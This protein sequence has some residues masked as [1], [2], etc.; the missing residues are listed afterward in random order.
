M[1]FLQWNIRGHRANCRELDILLKQFKPS[2]VALQ[3]TL[4]TATKELRINNFN[5]IS[6]PASSDFARRGVSLYIRNSIF[7][8]N[9]PLSSDLE[10]AAARVS[11]NKTITIC[12]LYLS[13]STVISKIKL[14]SLIHQ[15][16]RP[17]LLL[18][19]F[20]GHSSFWGSADTNNQG[21]VIEDFIS[22]HSLCLLNTGSPTFCA[23]SGSLTHVDLS[24]CDPSLFLD[25]E[26]QVHSDLC[27]SDHFP[28]LTSFKK[29]TEESCREFWKFKAANWSLYEQLV[30]EELTLQVLEDS[31]DPILQFS[32]ILLQCAEK[33]I[34][35]YHAKPNLV[36]TPWFDEECKK[37]KNERKKAQRQFHKAPSDENKMKYQALRA[38]CRLTFKKKKKESWE[39]FCSSLSFKTNTQKVWKIIKK[40]NGK[41]SRESLKCLKVNDRV[42]SNKKEVADILANTFHQNSSSENY[43]E[44]FQSVKRNAEKKPC[45]FQKDSAQDYN[46]LFNINELKDAITKTNNSAP[47]PDEIHYQFIRHLPP[48]VLTILLSLFNYIWSSDFFP[49]SW[50]EA[51]IIAIPKP[52]KDHSNPS[53]YRP[54]ALTSC[55]CKTME[56]MVYTRLLWKLEAVRA[57]DIS[58]CGFRKNHS[59]TDHLVGYETF[60]RNALINGDHVVSVLFDLEKA[61]DT[62]WK[63]GILQ[64]L[65]SLDF[66]GNLPIFIAKFLSNRHFYVRLHSTMSDLFVQEMGVPQGSILSPLL[67]NLKVNNIVKAVK[68]GLEKYLFVDDFTISVKGKTLAGIE[69]QLQLCINDLQKWVMRNGFKLSTSKTECIHFHRKRCQVLEPDIYLAGQRLRVSNKVK[70]LGV[71]FDSKLSFLPHIKFLKQACQSGLN[72]LKVISHT[73]WGADK[74]TLLRLYRS[75]V[76][77]KLDYGCVVYGS[78][79]E[80]YLKALDPIHHQGLRIAL[81]AFR[82]SPIQSLYAEAGEPPLRLRRIRLSMKYYLKLKTLPDNPAYDSVLNPLF[83]LKF[84]QKPK[85]IKPLG[86]RV[87]PYFKEANIDVGIVN[88]SS[89]TTDI[90]PWKL[91][92][93]VINFQLTLFKKEVTPCLVFKQAFW[94][95]CEQYKGFTRI[96]T[97]GSK[98]GDKAS[99]AVVCQTKLNKPIK[100]RIPD[101]SSIYTAELK[102][103]Q[104][105][106]QEISHSNRRDFLILVD[107]LSA[108]SALSSGNITHPF[109][110][111]VHDMYTQLA[112]RGKRV[113][114]MW[115]PSHVGI[116]GNVLVDKAAKEALD[117]EMPRTPLQF[118]P[119]SDFDC[120]IYAYCF[121]LWQ[122]EWS[123]EVNNKLFKVRPNLSEPLTLFTQNRKQESVL[124]RL[125]IGHTYLTHGWLLRKEEPPWCD[126]CNSLLSVEHILTKCSAFSSS[127]EK[128][129]INGQLKDI[130][131][132]VPPERIFDFLR[133]IKLFHKI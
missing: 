31:E 68:P 13:P 55:L 84:D 30:K 11:L 85:E 113:V 49:S 93:P 47:G 52:G 70:F 59:T 132:N 24:I 124:S 110:A 114:F 35:K 127:R 99:A 65:A 80:S 51:I 20:N 130:F 34:P 38:K 19:D 9:I 53:N 64:D 10:A 103:I 96:F 45:D 60:I 41:N 48:E 23:S 26:W 117:I 1:D 104:L 98:K 86:L 15:L 40:I 7:Y 17:F 83:Q 133:E 16:P 128:F 76:R 25:L 71:I 72:V 102:A 90:P 108:L 126:K 109:L 119:Y 61:Y 44:E 111:D 21:K 118:I 29:K 22:D 122:K 39:K 69:R 89:L 131:T 78:A 58:Q 79:R 32:E 73:D 120:K 36:K 67:F 81:G 46:L 75:L 125:H 54:I 82:T 121:K 77:P 56:R 8:D 3:E 112:L 57:L 92:H 94:E 116:F 5:C 62:T 95:Q 4:T 123:N 28:I 50:K 18:G 87:K 101:S 115:I 43:C 105:A 88:D 2:V 129:F 97:D 66:I 74:L 91:A 14:E 42:I 37:L 33:S 27:G 12:T 63:Y 107:S 106:L 100:M 6:K